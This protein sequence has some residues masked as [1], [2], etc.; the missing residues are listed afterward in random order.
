VTT[1][2]G[3]LA[4]ENVRSGPASVTVRLPSVKVASQAP[5]E[6]RTTVRA[7]DASRLTR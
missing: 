2:S 7:G 3:V 4:S 5:V 1:R 6:V